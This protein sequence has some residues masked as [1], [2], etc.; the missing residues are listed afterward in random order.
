MNYRYLTFHERKFL[1]AKPPT[2]QAG[3]EC[4]CEAWREWTLTEADLEVAEYLNQTFL[5][6]CRPTT[7]TLTL[8]HH[9]PGTL[10]SFMASLAQ[11][12]CSLNLLLETDFESRGDVPPSDSVLSPLLKRRT[13]AR[14]CVLSCHLGEDAAQR[15]T[16]QGKQR[17]HSNE[18]VTG[19]LSAR[20]VTVLMPVLRCLQVLKV[21]VS[22]VEVLEA[23]NQCLPLM[24]LLQELDVN[25]T[26]SLL[27]PSEDIPALAYCR[28]FGLTLRLPGISDAK[29]EWAGRVA[30]FLNRCYDYIWLTWCHMTADGGIAFLRQLSANQILV[31]GVSVFSLSGRPSPQQVMSLSVMAAQLPAHTTLHW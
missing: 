11:T 17:T 22:S 18:D 12:P 8:L 4:V 6:L 19:L 16:L 2:L 26:L 13:R 7:V 24:T 20:P 27:Q 25:L 23:L 28:D 9:H 5:E 3:T 30:S 15:F 29:A 1:H 21:R 10:S 31:K 14:L